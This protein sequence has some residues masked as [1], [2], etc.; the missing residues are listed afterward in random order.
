MS[1]KKSSGLGRGLAALLDEASRPGASKA[2]PGTADES[3]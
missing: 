3:G 2:Q 1:D